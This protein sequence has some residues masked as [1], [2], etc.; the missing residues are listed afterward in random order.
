ML[1]R[2]LGSKE[3]NR[4]YPFIIQRDGDYCLLCANAVALGIGTI[5]RRSPAPPGRKWDLDHANRNPM[6][7]R[8]ENVHAVCHEHNQWLSG[9]PPGKHIKVVQ[10]GYVVNKRERE[11]KSLPTND[12]LFK[13]NCGYSNA[14]P[15]MKANIVFESDWIKAAWDILIEGPSPK[16]LFIARCAK[17]CGCAVS[18][19]RNNFYEKHV[20]SAEPDSPFEEFPGSGEIM[21]RLKPVVHQAGNGHNGNGHKNPDEIS[22]TIQSITKDTLV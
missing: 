12:S 15:E 11:S 18:T 2:R 1:S 3:R 13:I 21:V 8:P 6:D 17:R 16:R 20:Y 14:S 4:I 5:N 22:R 9:Q 10:K 19:S 7:W